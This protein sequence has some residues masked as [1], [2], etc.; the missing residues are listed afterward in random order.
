MILLKR[1]GLMFVSVL[2]S[3]FVWDVGSK[4]EQLKCRQYTG[5]DPKQD[6]I[7]QGKDKKQQLHGYGHEDH[8]S[9][10]DITLEEIPVP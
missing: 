9:P 10:G 7:F 6:Q 1:S 2:V 8:L 5:Y 4:I 3:V